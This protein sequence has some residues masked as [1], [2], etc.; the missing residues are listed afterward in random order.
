M[1]ERGSE[2]LLAN[3]K[4]NYA[5][6]KKIASV[7]NP[8][9]KKR[10]LALGS[11]FADDEVF[12]FEASAREQ[13]EPKEHDTREVEACM[14]LPQINEGVAFDLLDWWKR[15]STLWPKLSRM[16]RQYICLPATFVAV[17]LLFTSSGVM[18]WDFHKNTKEETLEYLMCM[19]KNA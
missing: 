17:E 8:E 7:T 14:L 9:P 1:R 3:F 18:N 19:K 6:K 12:E 11:F 2:W 5:P 16:T 4:K 13:K 15:W 10:K